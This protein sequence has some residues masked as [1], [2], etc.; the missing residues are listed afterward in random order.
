MKPET[1][2]IL[3]TGAG[4]LLIALKV[5]RTVEIRTLTLTDLTKER[6]PVLMPGAL[7]LPRDR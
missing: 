2:Q 6:M 5:A 1:I 7:I 3:L 4:Q